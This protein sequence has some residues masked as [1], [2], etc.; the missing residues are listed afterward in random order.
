LR[1]K[2]DKAF[3]ECIETPVYRD[4]EMLELPRRV[5]W[6]ALGIVMENEKCLLIIENDVEIA[7]VF[8]MFKRREIESAGSFSQ[9][10]EEY[11]R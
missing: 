4:F 7:Q 1:S 9:V 10:P 8:E 3:S 5:I 11:Q 6:K 2:R